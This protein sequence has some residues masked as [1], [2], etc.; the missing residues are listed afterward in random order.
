[1]N[2]P[3]ASTFATAAAAVSVGILAAH[4]A[5]P[6]LGT[7][8]MDTPALN[9]AEAKALKNP[10]ANTQSSIKRGRTLYLTSGC[11]SCHGNDGK[12]M[13]E[14]VANATDLTNPTIYKNG[15]AEG[16]VF[17]SIRDGAGVA[18]PPFKAQISHEEDIWHLVNFVRS[19]WP[20]GQK[21][22]LAAE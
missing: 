5:E 20:A 9:P 22:P 2:K 12:A 17:R 6:A 3:F 16:E 21:P 14:V 10:V 4:A 18:M 11:V 13:I 7:L 19:L 8:N 1:M 15:T